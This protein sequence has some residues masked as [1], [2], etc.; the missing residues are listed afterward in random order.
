[1][2]GAVGLAVVAL[3]IKQSHHLEGW[4][5]SGISGLEK[6]LYLSIALTDFFDDVF[7]AHL[8]H[9]IVDNNK[10][11]VFES[12]ESYA[13]LAI[14]G[15]EHAVSLALEQEANRGQDFFLVVNDENCIA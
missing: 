15:S 3:N 10:M 14:T 4:L 8:G 7:A 12:K 5:F 9:E 1:M 11:D 6:N 2:L 13:V